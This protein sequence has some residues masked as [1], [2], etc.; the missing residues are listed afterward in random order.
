VQDTHCQLEVAVGMHHCLR[1][2]GCLEEGHKKGSSRGHMGCSSGGNG[3]C[4]TQSVDGRQGQV[5][6]FA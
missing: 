2:G 4:A 1:I 5:A 3:I 6:E